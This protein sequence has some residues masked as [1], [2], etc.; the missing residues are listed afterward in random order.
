M[1]RASFG[2]FVVLVVDD[3]LDTLT[4]AACLIG[5]MLGCKVLTASSGDGA[6]T[7]V[8]QHHVD[9]VFADIVMP[10]MHGLTLARIIQ[11]RFPDMPV[12]LTTGLPGVVNMA[13]ELGAVALIK[14]YEPELLVAIFGE[15]LTTSERRTA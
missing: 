5:D 7:I 1:G 10:K 15:F 11:Q 3:D 14:P 8:E 4:T 9:L 12:V 2:N 6:L 13:E